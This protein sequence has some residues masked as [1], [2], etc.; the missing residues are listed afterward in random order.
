MLNNINK[1]NFE[2]KYFLKVNINEIMLNI[3]HSHSNS[4]PIHIHSGFSVFGKSAFSRSC[5]LLL[6][7]SE[8]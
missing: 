7:F 6:W 5:A 1:I 3:C 8:A 4:S 2:S